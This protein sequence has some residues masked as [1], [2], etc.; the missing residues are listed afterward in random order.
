MNRENAKRAKLAELGIDYSFPG[1]AAKPVANLEEPVII[2]K[3]VKGK[4]EKKEKKEKKDKIE[5]VSIFLKNRLDRVNVDQ[6]V[7][8]FI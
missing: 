4:K 6:V 1:H 5:E 2:V 7:L 8:S 3:E